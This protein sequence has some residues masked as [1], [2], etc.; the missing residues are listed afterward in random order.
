MAKSLIKNAL[1]EKMVNNYLPMN[2][3]NAITFAQNY[4]EGTWKVY[5]ST[6]E[7]G[8]DTGVAS[9]NDVNVF[10]TDTT[11]GKKAYLRF[12]ANATKNETEIRTA[13]IGLTIDGFIVDKVSIIN[14]APMTFA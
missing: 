10:L 3:S 7:T 12:I 9:A 2:A 11:S 14:F 1:G 5:S 6:A 4:L 13:L 8:S